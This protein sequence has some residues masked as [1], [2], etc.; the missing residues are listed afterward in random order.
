[1]GADPDLISVLDIP[2]DRP[3]K[4]PGFLIALAF[5]QF[6]LFLALLGPVMVSLALKIN[7]LVHTS[8]E[9]TSAIG[10][11]LGAGA[12]AALVSNA[13]FGRLSD[14][15]TGRLGRRRPWMIGGAIVLLIALLIMAVATNTWV[16]GIGWF[17]AQ[18]G[19]NAAFAPY[20]ATLS[21]Q[22]NP[23]QYARA[24]AIVGIMQNVGIL[25]AVWLASLLTDNM[26]LLFLIP[27][28][29]AL[30]A[31]IIY[32]FVIDDKPMAVR[33]EPINL[34]A[35]LKSFWVNPLKH[36]DFG[37][38]WWSRFFVILSSFL[39]TTFR[40][41]YVMDRL[42]LDTK[43]ATATIATGVLIYT[44]TLVITGYLS[45][46]ISDKTG[47]R[48][49]LVI[50]SAVVFAVGTYFLMHVSSVGQF[51]AVEALIG[52]GYG[53]YMAIDMALVL[54]VIPNPQDA[55]RD[56]GVFNMANALPQ[57]LAP[58]LGGILLA[59]T[60]NPDQPNFGLLFLVAA[61]AALLGAV[62]IIPIKKA[63]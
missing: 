62:F 28:V 16:L 38:A 20:I 39:F 37:F 36:P 59:V 32:S 25:A 55:G 14:L 60:A 3:K 8:T 1:M 19:A 13:L 33:P 51:Y 22:L 42:A 41:P 49:W 44:I 50:L 2:E 53:I 56:L 30:V 43:T 40:L 58:V 46:W 17:I 10:G 52:A 61:I 11:I 24:S 31:F 47:K 34:V 27:G 6:A 15:T 48:K 7:T 21:D 54:Q 9:A 18:I 45:G 29:I 23:K 5:A 4:G 57:S 26:L 35:I 12:L 63:Q